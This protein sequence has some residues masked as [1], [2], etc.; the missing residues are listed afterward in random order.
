M[1]W[2]PNSLNRE[3]T[4]LLVWLDRI[5]GRYLAGMGLFAVVLGVGSILEYWLLGVPY[6][7]IFGVLTGIISLI[8]FIGG[9]LSGLIV[10]I[11]CLL[12]GSTRF[13]GLS[14]FTFAV[15][16]ALIN[17]V[18]CQISY[19]FV[20]LP[21]IGKLIKLPYWVVLSGVMLGAAFNSILFAFLVIP[22]FSTLRLIYTYVLSKIVGREP[23]P[24]QETPAEGT[25][26]FLSQFML[27]EKAQVNSE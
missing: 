8:P 20:A 7:V 2:V 18:I 12:F 22:V 13:T 21:I 6:P 14:P 3:F 15:I 24:D 1:K 4:L 11:P 26:G 9:F 10:F 25:Q 17:D 27:G 16:V 5:W 19:N 23:F